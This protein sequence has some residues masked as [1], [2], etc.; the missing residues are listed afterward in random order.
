[1]QAKQG[2]FRLDF[3]EVKGEQKGYKNY[4]SS[5]TH[6]TP[7]ILYYMLTHCFFDIRDPY[8]DATVKIWMFYSVQTFFLSFSYC[9]YLSTYSLLSYFIQ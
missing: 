5:E 9:S 7:Y 4:K 8:N 6:G 3:F 2:K 1:M